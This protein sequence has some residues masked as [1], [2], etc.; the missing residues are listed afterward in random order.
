MVY[1]AIL[2]FASTGVIMILLTFVLP[3]L[4]KSFE[5]SGLALPIFT[6]V[7]IAVSSFLASHKIGVLVILIAIISFLFV[8][9]RKPLGKR[10]AFNILHHAPISRSLLKQ[11][12][13]ARFSRTLK[14]L[15]KSG[16]PLV[17]GLHIVS[18]AVGDERYRLEIIS[19]QEEIRRGFSL[20]DIFKKREEY[21]PNLV[22]SLIAVGERTGS[23]ERS[24]ETIAAFYEE[25]VDRSLKSLVTFLEPLLL[26][27]MGLIVGGIAISVL[28]PIYQLIGQVR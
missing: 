8:F 20:S 24:L 14:N 1:P 5:K 10:I 23:L 21:F 13:L 11:L 15:I 25:E 19:M 22:T 26:L 7:L 3:R 27:F 18:T 4:T 17:E 2:L 28:L 12:A 9:L 6:Q 16:I